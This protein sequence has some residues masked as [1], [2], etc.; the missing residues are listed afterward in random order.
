MVAT[1]DM[2]KP[3]TTTPRPSLLHRALRLL[4]FSGLLVAAPCG[5]VS[6]PFGSIGGDW[7][8]TCD[9]PRQQ[10][11]ACG[12]SDGCAAGLYCTES[13][14][15]VL[16]V[17]KPRLAAGSACKLTE[18]CQSGLVCKS[19]DVTGDCYYQTCDKNGVCTQG[20]ASGA[21]CDAKGKDC[22]ASQIC[23]LG[24]IGPGT[25]IAAPKVGD[26]CDT[27]AGIRACGEKLAC[28]RPSFTCGQPPG[29]GQMCALAPFRCAPG[30]AC[31][32]LNDPAKLD[33]F[34]GKPI[35]VGGACTGGGQC[36]KGAFCDLSKLVC[37]KNRTVGDS[38]KNGNECGEP[39]FDVHSGVECVQGECV[40]TS[41]V[42]G[43]CWPGE[44]NKCSNGLTCVPKAG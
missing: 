25:C 42:G 6:G 16:G 4:S 2:A 24:T 9:K 14:T 33:D 40:D 37:T 1:S 12:T 35:A 20:A 30:L 27:N 32:W 13:G 17:C 8:Y 38:C 28:L 21:T 22:P 31:L 39:P 26:P 19:G 41:V 5:P 29:E 34:C 36:V 3:A 18:D 10:G 44:E 11:E 43:K 15:S 23:A 7:K